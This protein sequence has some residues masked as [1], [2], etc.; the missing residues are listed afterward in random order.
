MAARLTP[1]NLFVTPLVRAYKVF[2]WQTPLLPGLLPK[3]R[4][5]S[6]FSAPGAGRGRLAGLMQLTGDNLA[7]ERGGREVFSAA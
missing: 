1:E 3:M 2:S 4:G 5:N 7:C 6:G